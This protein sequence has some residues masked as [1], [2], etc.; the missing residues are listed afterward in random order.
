MGLHPPELHFTI[1]VTLEQRDY[2]TT[3]GTGVWKTVSKLEI[4]PRQR[5]AVSD[6][7]L[8]WR[9][10][11]CLSITRFRSFD[12]SRWKLNMWQISIQT[13]SWKAQNLRIDICWFRTQRR[14]HPGNLLL[15]W[16]TLSGPASQDQS[17]ICLN[18]WPLTNRTSTCPVFRA[19]K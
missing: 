19:T 17:R 16:A 10:W 8:V 9:Q 12:M 18:G 13:R 6:T 15:T 5:V 11:I 1:D 14:Y 3:D 2:L 4:G 7:H